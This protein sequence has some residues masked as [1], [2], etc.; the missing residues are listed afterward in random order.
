MGGMNRADA[1]DRRAAILAAAVRV[2]AREGIAE[3]TTRKIAAE[4]GIN[5]AT[6]LYYMGS[7]DELLM[8]VLCE[9][10]R[11]T[12]EA[13][14]TPL[15]RLIRDAA[16]FNPR[17][18]IRRS[19]W[20]F[21]EQVEAAPE[22]QVMQYELTLYALRRPDSAW[23]AREQYD[24]YRAVVEELLREAYARSGM[25]CAVPFDALARFIVGGLDGL[26]LQFISARDTDR[27]RRDLDQIIAAVI[28][29][30][31]GAARDSG[32][33]REALS[34]GATQG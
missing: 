9:M 18:A 6:L 16:R 15:E 10:M 13:A 31:E 5:Q 25:R 2:L 23:L 27:A 29:L 14:R 1:T 34:S 28:A 33:P 24:G 20:A 3:A 8:A 22:L 30:A 21:W 4:A 19:M 11:L 17:E 26:I 7:K 12:A 32:P